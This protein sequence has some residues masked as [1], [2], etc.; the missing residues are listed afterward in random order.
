[1]SFIPMG[2]YKTP[3]G[4]GGYTPTDSDALA[5]VNKV[6]SVGGT[7]S[8]TEKEAVDDL[9]IGLKTD[10]Q[11][12]SGGLMYLFMG[13]TPASTAIEAL[14]PND[15]DTQ[16]TY[17]GVLTNQANHTSA[18]ISVFYEEVGEAI[19]NKGTIDVLSNFY[20]SQLGVKFSQDAIGFIDGQAIGNGLTDGSSFYINTFSNGS[21][22][23]TIGFAQG[24]TN[25][26]SITNYFKGYPLGSSIYYSRRQTSVDLRAFDGTTYLGVNN[27]NVNGTSL[28][29]NPI[30]FFRGANLK[31]TIGAGWVWNGGTSD[32]PY[33][34]ISTFLTTIGR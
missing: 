4:G 20:Q 10:N 24:Y 29:S 34:R 31:G 30:G 26:Q 14:N 16:L 33:D 2:F 19:S 18:G 23:G 32:S 25:L 12:T 6:E 21:S 8:D 7:M 15:I 13:G 28:S 17:S 1:M 5:Y 3:G 27:T 11:Y 9:F 22:N